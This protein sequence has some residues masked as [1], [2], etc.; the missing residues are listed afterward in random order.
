MI[1]LNVILAHCGSFIPCDFAYIPI[2]DKVLTRLGHDD[3]ANAQ[4]S[5]FTKEMAEVGFII[6]EATA[7]SLVIIDELGRGTS[8]VDATALTIAIAET[9][10]QKKCTLF[11]ITHLE[12][13][14]DFFGNALGVSNLHLHVTENNLCE[15]KIQNGISTVKNYGLDLARKV[16][17]DRELVALAN[18]IS[19]RLANLGI[20]AEN[21]SR[22][23]QT[24]FKLKTGRLNLIQCKDLWH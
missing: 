24:K 2:F 9:F 8:V 14:C 16:G 11:M 4:V 21:T 7:S 23:R 20:H 1:A 12:A 17:F 5:S 13:V 6:S 10:M 18:D 15:F 22:N 3:D 19:V